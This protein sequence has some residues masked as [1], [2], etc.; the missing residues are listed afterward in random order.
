MIR[1]LAEKNTSFCAACMSG[2][3]RSVRVKPTF[4]NRHFCNRR[5]ISA[6]GPDVEKIRRGT[7]RESRLASRA[8]QTVHRLEAES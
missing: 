7:D 8:H 2:E 5:R 6:D 3:I 1:A 4:C